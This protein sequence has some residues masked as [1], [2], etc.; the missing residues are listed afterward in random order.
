M[1]SKVGG[2]IETTYLETSFCNIFT[3]QLPTVGLFVLID[4]CFHAKVNME[5]V[6][7]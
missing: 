2:I 3:N 5:Y 1:N 7:N 6:M 4:L